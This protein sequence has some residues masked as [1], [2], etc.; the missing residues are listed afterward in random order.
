MATK[1]LSPS[2]QTAVLH[3]VIRVG[4]EG[5]SPF[6]QTFAIVEKLLVNLSYA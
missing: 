6:S 4:I 2:S 5:L 1:G 3:A